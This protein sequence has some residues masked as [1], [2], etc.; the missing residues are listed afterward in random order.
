MSTGKRVLV[1]L[2]WTIVIYLAISMLV[3]AVIGFSSGL[4]NAD[5]P[6]SAAMAQNQ[7][8]IEKWVA[9]MLL[10]SAVAA[11]VGTWLKVLPGTKG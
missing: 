8:F 2:G 7:Q 9:P 3:G 11:G 1:G 6:Y 4:T 10:L 5:D